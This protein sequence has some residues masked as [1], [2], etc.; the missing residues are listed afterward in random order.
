MTCGVYSWDFQTISQQLNDA[1]QYTQKKNITEKSIHITFITS[2]RIYIIN[3][4][5]MYSILLD[6]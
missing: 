1:L 3:N 2:Q 4:I 6:L 5:N